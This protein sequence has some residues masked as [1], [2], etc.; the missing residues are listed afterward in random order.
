MPTVRGG[1][2]GDGLVKAAFLTAIANHQHRYKLIRGMRYKR[3]SGLVRCMFLLP[4]MTCDITHVTMISHLSDDQ[5]LRSCCIAVT[6]ML[7]TLYINP[8]P[9]HLI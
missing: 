3:V 4:H 8:C 9:M 1:V 2:E 7:C 6:V 5:W